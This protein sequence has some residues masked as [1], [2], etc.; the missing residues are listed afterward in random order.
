MGDLTSSELIERLIAV[1]K[2]EDVLSAYDLLQGKEVVA[3]KL[4]AYMDSRM[5]ALKDE[6][7]E[8]YYQASHDEYQWFEDDYYEQESDG[9]LIDERVEEVEEIKNVLPYV[10]VE[11]ISLLTNYH[12]ATIEPYLVDTIKE[13]LEEIKYLEYTEL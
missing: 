2:V 11:S 8:P 4:L 3:D 9:C 1:N 6:E 12:Y 5:L 7:Y 10:T 13:K